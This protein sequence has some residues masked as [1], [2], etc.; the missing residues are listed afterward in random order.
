[1]QDLSLYQIT[2][3]FPMLI[4]Q[5]EMTE[6]DKKKVEKELIELLQQKSQNLIGY[7]RN[8]ELTIE[9]MKNEEKRI[10]EQR[11]TLENRL[12]KFKEYVKECMEQ[13]GFTKLETPLGTLSIAK[14]PPS[15]E[16]INEEE[17]P[18]E[19]KTEIVTV[20]VDKTAIKEHFKETGEIP[21]GDGPVA[22]LSGFAGRGRGRDGARRRRGGCRGGFGGGRRRARTSGGGA[23]RDAR[24]GP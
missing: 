5:E 9:A 6:E 22:G 19:Y 2:N 12:T 14:N 20:K 7:T 21:A 11:K 24:C 1:M 16:I 10:S 13:G 4:A 15:V 8:I 17:I 3:A 23:G 18:G